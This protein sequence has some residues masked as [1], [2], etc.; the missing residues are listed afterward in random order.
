MF[1]N[2]LNE[3]QSLETE[4]FP[5]IESIQDHESENFKFRE[6]TTWN[7]ATRS[8]AVLRNVKWEW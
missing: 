2:L 6:P 1:F 3:F 5:N 4:T 7:R 8:L